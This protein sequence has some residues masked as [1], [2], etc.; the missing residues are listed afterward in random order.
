M[1]S[2]DGDAEGPGHGGAGADVVGDDQ[3]DRPIKNITKKS[4]ALETTSMFPAAS[5]ARWSTQL[6]TLTKEIGTHAVPRAIP[7]GV[8]RSRVGGD[9]VI[10]VV[11]EA[12]ERHGI[13][14]PGQLSPERLRANADET[15]RLRGLRT[16]LETLKR[17]VDASLAEADGTSWEGATTAYSMLR[18]L[19]DTDPAL[20]DSL[21]PAVAFFTPTVK[22]TKAKSPE[23]KKMPALA[24][25]TNSHST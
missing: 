2:V 9:H 5:V 20:A 13:T 17:L 22:K 1:S 19:G 21:A 14:L 10:T 18:R 23:E 7:T 12:C 24:P 8:A 4:Q 25:A 16:Q 11:L 6:E 3:E 15:R